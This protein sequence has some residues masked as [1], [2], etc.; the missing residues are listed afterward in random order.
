MC[1]RDRSYPFTEDYWINKFM[2]IRERVESI[3]APVT[4]TAGESF[5]VIANVI[6]SQE[7]PEVLEYPAE[8]AYVAVRLKDAAGNTIYETEMS[9]VTAGQ[10]KATIP[11][12]VTE[13]LPEGSYTIEVLAGK[14]SGLIT[15]TSSVEIVLTV[16]TPPP[17]TEAPTTT[18][19]P[20]TAPPTTTPPPPPTTTP[21]PPGPNW[22][23]IGGVIVV[24]IIVV[25]AIL[26]LRK[27]S[28]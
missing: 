25:A 8:E 1:I 18:P 7:Y 13:G 15:G 19:P 6:E 12:S 28:E 17:T 10:F 2:V 5:D 16:P 27:K 22:A 23:L 14:T 3:Q 21:P 4:V 9:L 11:G 26:L 20:T 24:I